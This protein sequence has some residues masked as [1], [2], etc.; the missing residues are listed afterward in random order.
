VLADEPTGALDQRTAQ[1]LVELLV[2]LNVEEQVTLIVVTHA[3][4]CAQRMGRT[5]SLR[6]GEIE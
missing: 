6:D 5:V 3:E 4:A 1:A 2:Q